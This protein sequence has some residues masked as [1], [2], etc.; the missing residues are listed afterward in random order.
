[1]PAE[2]IEDFRDDEPAADD[3]SDLFPQTA[4]SP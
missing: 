2:S 3:C 1:M 4:I